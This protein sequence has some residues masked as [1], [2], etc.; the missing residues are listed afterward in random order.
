MDGIQTPF[1]RRAYANLCREF[2]DAASPYL[3]DILDRDEDK[4][5]LKNGLKNLAFCFRAPVT[6]YFEDLALRA[7]I[8]IS[9]FDFPQ[10]VLAARQ[11]HIAIKY[12]N[13]LAG[14]I[15]GKE[16]FSSDLIKRRLPEGLKSAAGLDYAK[17]HKLAGLER[18]IIRSLP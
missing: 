11:D 12:A 5:V 8:F 15:T 16:A 6:Y 4:D 3:V 1:R 9:Y 14:R 7:G 18:L 10:A 17:Q 13:S 2:I